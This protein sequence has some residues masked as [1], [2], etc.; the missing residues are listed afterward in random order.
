MKAEIWTIVGGGHGG[1]TFAGHM[2]LLGK[3]VRLYTKSQKKVDAININREIILKH[4]IEGVGKIEFAT[5]DI[6]KAIKGATHIVM[7]LP[8][9]WH[10]QTTKAMTPYLED[11]QF[12]L[13]LPEA[14][15]GAISFRKVLKDMGCKKKVVVGAGCTLPY[16]TRSEEPGVC[17]VCGLK[18]EVKIAALPASD[19]PLLE[20]A[21]CPSFPCFKICKNVI[22][23]SLD[24]INAMMHPGP[25]L[26]N[27]SRFEAIPE[28]RYEYYREGITPSIGSLLE[29][30]DLE[31]I[32]VAKA[33]GIEQRSLKR[34]YIEMYHCGDESMPL[35]KLIQNND[36]YIGIMNAKS[37]NERYVLEDIPYSLVAIS[38][39]GQIAR[40]PT[41]CI[42]AVCTLSYGILK[43][44]LE[45]GRTA[46]NLGIDKMTKDMLLKYVLFGDI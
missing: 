44:N 42:D 27:I 9:N 3:R 45:A 30:M 32:A 17:Y 19:N 28:Q 29:S 26:L 37:L 2:A 24:N 10:D 41:P 33:Y 16:A 6:A 20:A 14:S 13:I 11:D 8:S 18:K 43:N 5:N 38:A 36:G 4:S 35:W 25:T 21:F 23:T 7:I 31:R 15:C 34:T 1:Q 46:K 40:V 39:L 12:I 22:E